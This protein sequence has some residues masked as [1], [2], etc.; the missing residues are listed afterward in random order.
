MQRA[1]VRI[2]HW[3]ENQM[4]LCAPLQLPPMSQSE[5]AATFGVAKPTARPL[6]SG[7]PGGGTQEFFKNIPADE[8]MKY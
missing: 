8:P 6:D 1:V 3:R 2:Y 5:L 7:M 4:R